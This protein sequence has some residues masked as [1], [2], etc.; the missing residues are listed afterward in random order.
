[1]TDPTVFKAEEVMEKPTFWVEDLRF[2]GNKSFI[3]ASEFNLATNS[4]LSIVNSQFKPRWKTNVVGK[5]R[6]IS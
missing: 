5:S 6:K 2:P 1:V 3:G 4:Q